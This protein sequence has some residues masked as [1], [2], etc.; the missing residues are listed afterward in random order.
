MHTIEYKNLCELLLFVLR[1]RSSLFIK[2]AKMT[3][4]SIF[5]NGFYASNPNDFY[6]DDE[7]GFLTWVKQ[8]I[9][10]TNSATWE[11]WFINEAAGDEYQALN[12]YFNYLENY[13]NSI[14][15]QL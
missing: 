15:Q 12:L 3:N 2:E 6:F 7:K 4:L 1:N 14:R 13:Y 9:K 8:K 11:E 10:S 5:I